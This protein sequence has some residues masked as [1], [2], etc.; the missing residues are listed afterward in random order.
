[1]I[2]RIN[3]NDRDLTL[4]VEFVLTRG[5][6]LFVERIDV[7]G[8]TTTLDRVVRQQFKIVEGD[9]FNPREIRQSAERIR[10]LGYFENAE[11]EGRQGSS[12]DQVVIDVDVVEQPTGSLSLTGAYSLNSG[13]G[14]AIGL[15]ENNF[16]GRGQS[17]SFGISTAS[18]S[19]EYNIGFTEPYLLGRDLRFDLDFGVSGTDSSF[20]SYDTKRGYFLPAITFP[21]SERGKL[22]LAYSWKSDEM[23][24]RDNVSNGLVVASE[25]AEGS[26]KTS[27]LGVTYSWDSR[28]SGLNPNAGVLMEVGGEVGGLGGDNEYFKASTKVIAQTKVL[29]EEVTLRATFQAG[30]LKWRGSNFSR[31]IDRF[32]LTP[33]IMRGFEPAGIGPRDLSNGVDDAIGGNL[34]AVARFEA[35]FPL[36][37]PDELNIRGG[38]FYDIGNLWDLDNANTGASNGIVGTNGDARHVIGVSLLWDTVFGPLRLNF[39]NAI[40]KET[41]DKEQSFDLTIQ[42]RF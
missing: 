1:M 29:N 32:V 20:S 25:I 10:A 8:N 19:E 23:L 14:V 3:R 15:S 22:K 28:L 21:V 40:K 35:E 16:L 38:V 26:R 11:V 5:R 41:Y 6:R 33:D 24:V 27:A 34:F 2:P 39:S 30:A 4:D 18:D 36:G 9:P 31:T 37:L 17:L 13:F 7:E 12:E 42:A